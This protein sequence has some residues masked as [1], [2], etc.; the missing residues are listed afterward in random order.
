[1]FSERQSLRELKFL[2]VLESLFTLKL[3]NLKKKTLREAKA[4]SIVSV[5]KCV[6]VL[7][8][9]RAT[10]KVFLFSTANLLIT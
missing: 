10:S 6:F 2:F 3:G 4:S 8:T 7:L 9:E 5:S 1:M